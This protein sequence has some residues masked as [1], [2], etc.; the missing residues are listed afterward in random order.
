MWTFVHTG[1][2]IFSENVKESPETAVNFLLL[3]N[4]S[5]N[6]I[7]LEVTELDLLLAR[8]KSNGFFFPSLKI[9][10]L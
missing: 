9:N 3:Y 6:E 2:V 10:C 5:N 4:F 7:V 1:L 8:F